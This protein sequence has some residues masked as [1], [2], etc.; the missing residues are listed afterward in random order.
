MRSW[1]RCWPSSGTKSERM[2]RSSA[3]FTMVYNEPVFL[4]IWLRYYSRFFAPDD[5]YVLDQGSTDGSTSAGG[6]VRVPLDFETNDDLYRVKVSQ[7]LQRDLL[8]RYEVVLT[9]DVDEIIAPDPARATLRDYIDRFEADFVNSLAYEVLHMRGE[10]PSLSLHQPILTQRRYW[11]RNPG[12]D[13]PLLASVPISWIPGF[14]MQ[15]DAERRRDPNLRLIHLHRMDFG[16]CLDR[17]RERQGRE[18]AQTDLDVGRGYQ[19][20]II[21][22]AAF[23]R[24]FYDDS[25]FQADGVNIDPE[26]I[27]EA[28]KGLV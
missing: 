13:K 5:I 7:D 19:N 2:S 12:Y 8:E 1:G 27:P 17:H 16:L 23:E 4:P 10:E 6:F 24:W 22:E 3:V 26:P 14:H 25:C 21:E 11:Y 9:T 28:W 15:S 20:R 18:F